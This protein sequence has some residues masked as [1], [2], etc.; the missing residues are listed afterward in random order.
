[1][2]ID[3]AY[4]NYFKTMPWVYGQ[5]VTQEAWMSTCG[6]R[7]NKSWMYQ[8]YA[9]TPY[10]CPKCAD[11]NYG[12]VDCGNFPIYHHCRKCNEVMSIDYEGGEDV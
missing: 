4:V 1:M 10:V 5:L 3:E 2:L 11:I 12:W 8:G 7:G 9:G 6:A